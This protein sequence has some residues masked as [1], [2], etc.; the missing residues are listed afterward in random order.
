M[1]RINHIRVPKPHQPRFTTETCHLSNQQED[2]P[3]LLVFTTNIESTNTYDNK[4]IS[5]F[6]LNNGASRDFISQTEVNKRNLKTEVLPQK[7]R[8][9]LADGRSTA[10]THQCHV[11]F[12]VNSI[13]YFRTFIIVIN[14]NSAYDVILGM[15]FLTIV[16]LIGN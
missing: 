2:Y 14:M 10:A 11:Q 1:S 13:K 6:L 8:I 3:L 16:L 5:T 4:Y 12:I 7:I 15:P 9:V